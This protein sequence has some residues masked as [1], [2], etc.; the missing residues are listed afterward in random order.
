[1]FVGHT[2]DL[3]LISVDRGT[4]IRTKLKEGRIRLDDGRK[5]LINVGSVGHPRDGNSRAK[6]VLWDSDA[7]LL[8]VRGIPYPAHITAQKIIK[9]GFPRAYALCISPQQPAA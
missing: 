5:Y 1:F 8:D 4:V 6:Y 9:R 3:Q 2:H 7:G